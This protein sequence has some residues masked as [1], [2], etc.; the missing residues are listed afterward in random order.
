MASNDKRKSQPLDPD[1]L[2][3]RPQNQPR[4]EQGGQG[5]GQPGSRTGKH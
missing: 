4:P 5:S 1:K 2:G 3:Q